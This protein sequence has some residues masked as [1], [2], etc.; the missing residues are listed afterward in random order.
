MAGI[1]E[2][3]LE[4]VKKSQPTY[5]TT[6]KCVT[7]GKNTQNRCKTCHH[8][9][10][11]DS[12]CQAGFVHHQHECYPMDLALLQNSSNL[13]LID[14]VNKS[15]FAE[16]QAM[17][18]RLAEG[19]LKDV[20]SRAEYMIY[21]AVIEWI[22]LDPKFGDLPSDEEGAKK[23]HAASEKIK[24]AAH[25]LANNGRADDMHNYSWN[26]FIPKMLHS[27]IS[28]LWHGIGGWRD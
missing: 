26:P 21:G 14:A 28:S 2:Q 6:G 19:R 22:L 24:E 9:F 11:C 13:A 16:Y 23:F 18:Y 7:C 4:N 3:I 15:L 1:M 25:L 20:S 10:F 27:Q 8:R 5:L 12:N 17:G